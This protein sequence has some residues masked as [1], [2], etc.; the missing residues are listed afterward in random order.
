ML[1]DE[2]Q[3]TSQQFLQ[4]HLAEEAG[5]AG[6]QERARAYGHHWFAMPNVLAGS[7]ARFM[8]AAHARVAG[9]KMRGR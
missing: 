6:E 8:S 9:E 1:H 3:A 5:R 2:F 4:Q 7:M